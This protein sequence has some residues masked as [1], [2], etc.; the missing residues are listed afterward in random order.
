MRLRTNAI[1]SPCLVLTV[2]T[3][4]TFSR[5]TISFRFVAPNPSVI[6]SSFPRYLCHSS[7]PH[8]V[9]TILKYT[10]KVRV[11]FEACD[12]SNE[13]GTSEVVIW[14]QLVAG[15]HSGL[16]TLSF[17]P[18]KYPGRDIGEGEEGLLQH[19]VRTDI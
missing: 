6:V 16:S 18:F 13:N 10:T 8:R 19:K 11:I 2:F 1:G 4:P 14:P 7:L 17:A 9:K 3:L 12:Q 15:G 5:V